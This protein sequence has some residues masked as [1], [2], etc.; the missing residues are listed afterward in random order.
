MLEQTQLFT[1]SQVSHRAQRHRFLN[2]HTIDFFLQ[3][4][5]QPHPR[6]P[7]SR[8]LLA[9]PA[10]VLSNTREMPPFQR[11]SDSS[12]SFPSVLYEAVEGQ[13]FLLPLWERTIFAVYRVLSSFL[14]SII[15]FGLHILPPF[16]VLRKKLY[17]SL[18]ILGGKE[19][20]SFFSKGS[21]P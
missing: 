6:F 21:P 16:L 5:T 8:G 18:A 19:E 12:P 2:I 17:P 4:A 11:P 15:L 14:V 10:P 7:S 9:A 20:H 13:A 3:I 1:Y